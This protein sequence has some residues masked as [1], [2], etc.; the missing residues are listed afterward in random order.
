MPA[1]SVPSSLADHPEPIG[2]VIFRACPDGLPEEIPFGQALSKPSVFKAE[3]VIPSLLGTR[4][5]KAVFLLDK[6]FSI[7]YKT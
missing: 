1:I 6:G 5:R 2:L 7:C 4:R 3:Q